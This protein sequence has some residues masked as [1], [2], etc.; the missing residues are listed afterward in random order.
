MSSLRTVSP[1]ARSL[2]PVLSVVCPGLVSALCLAIPAHASSAEDKFILTPDAM[3]ELELRAAAANPR[4][5]VFLYT[6]LVHSMTA[7]AGKEIADGDTDQAAITLKQV[8]KYAHL[9]H[10]NLA[11]NA[12]KLKDAEELMHNTTYRLAQVL[13]LVSGPDKATVQDT[14]KQLDQ[15]N[16][17]ILTQVFTH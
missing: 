4:E 3:A 9:I 8:N 2:G 12:K 7:K 16:D 11:R 14:L 13:H 1:S 5:Q 6:E 15:V 10:V 17:E